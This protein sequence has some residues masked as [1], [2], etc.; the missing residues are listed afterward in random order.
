MR[1]QPGGYFLTLT[2]KLALTLPLTLNLALPLALTLSSCQQSEPHSAHYKAIFRPELGKVFRGVDMY[3]DLEAVRKI[4]PAAPQHDD[5]YGFIF[6]YRLDDTRKY[7]IEYICK[8]PQQRTVNSM[9]ANIFMKDEG[10]TTDL[11]QEIETDL[12][13][14]YGPP[15]GRLGDLRWRDDASDLVALLRILDDRKSLSV[16]FVPAS[17]F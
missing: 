9:V 11:Y 17:G 4:E 16:N 13:V 14:R 2:L 12:R 10:E 5:K 15:E 6:Q 1:C 3:M 7:Y 8:N